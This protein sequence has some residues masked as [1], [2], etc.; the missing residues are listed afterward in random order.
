MNKTVSITL[1]SISLF[2]TSPVMGA[3]DEDILDEITIRVIE[4]ENM[5]INVTDIALPNIAGEHGVDLPDAANNANER[6]ALAS[7]NAAEAA[8]KASENAAQAAENAAG[9]AGGNSGNNPGNN[10]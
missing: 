8:E 1:L 5:S 6:A 3:P 10:N 7:E 2:F 9:H 4:N